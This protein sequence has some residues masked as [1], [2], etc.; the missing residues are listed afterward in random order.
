MVLGR[1]SRVAGRGLYVTGADRKSRVGKMIL[2]EIQV[3]VGDEWLKMTNALD[4]VR[5]LWRKKQRLHLLM[6]WNPYV[7]KTVSLGSL[8]LYFESGVLASVTWPHGRKHMRSIFTL[9]CMISCRCSWPQERLLLKLSIR[10]VKAC[11]NFPK[12]R[13]LILIR[14]L[15]DA[16][17]M[18][19]TNK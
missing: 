13:Q 8:Y 14:P 2:R 3:R 12:R 5:R 6:L 4:R 11:M 1:G 10:L 9:A 19:T 15:C 16:F 17:L 7:I 18:K